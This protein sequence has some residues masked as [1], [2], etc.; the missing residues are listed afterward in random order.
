VG[1][2]STAGEDNRADPPVAVAVG[3]EAGVSQRTPG[4][5]EGGELGG[6]FW[7]R[8]GVGMQVPGGR[9]VGAA[10]FGG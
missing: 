5:M 8:V 4:L 6:R 7:R 1:Q 2:R 3:L 9:P 10:E